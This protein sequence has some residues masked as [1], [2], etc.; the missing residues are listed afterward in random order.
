M[1]VR[2][3]LVGLDLL[4]SMSKSD[5]LAFCSL[6]VTIARGADLPCPLAPSRVPELSAWARAYAEQL[7][8]DGDDITAADVKAAWEMINAQ[9]ASQEAAAWATVTSDPPVPS[10]S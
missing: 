5:S 2:V 8:E 7:A 10:Q 9:Q 4:Q 1:T 3:G 6:S